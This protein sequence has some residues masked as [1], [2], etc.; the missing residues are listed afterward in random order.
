MAKYR[1]RVDCYLEPT[2]ADGVSAGEHSRANGEFFVNLV[3]HISSSMADLGI[4][5]LAWNYGLG[6]SDWTF[7]D[8]PGATGRNAFA[9][10]RF[11]SASFGKFDC[12]IYENTGSGG[13][14]NH[15]G[16]IYINNQNYLS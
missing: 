6:G 11:H 14:G 2:V 16:S 9:C 13:T 3:Q 10:F 1:A 4:E 7:W 12:L 5:M 8:E 15:T